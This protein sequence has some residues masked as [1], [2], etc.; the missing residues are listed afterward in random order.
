MV[1]KQKM[2]FFWIMVPYTRVLYDRLWT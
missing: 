1:E 2:V